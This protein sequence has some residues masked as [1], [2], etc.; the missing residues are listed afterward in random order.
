[1]WYSLEILIKNRTLTTKQPVEKKKIGF[2]V[3]FQL[4]K[5]VKQV[6]NATMRDLGVEVNPLISI[7]IYF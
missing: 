7:K 6:T 1:M 3:Q 4:E 5:E 2:S